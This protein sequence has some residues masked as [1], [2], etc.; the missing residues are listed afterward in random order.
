MVGA[1]FILMN[2]VLGKCCPYVLLNL[3]VADQFNNLLG[4]KNYLAI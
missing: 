1:I 2:A 4:T 3:H